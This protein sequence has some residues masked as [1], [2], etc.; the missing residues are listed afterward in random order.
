MGLNE[1]YLIVFD[2]DGTL[3]TSDKTISKKTKDKLIELKEKGN[4]ISLAS[5]RPPRTILPYYDEL[6]LDG[7]FVSY[8][9]ACLYDPKE[10]RPIRSIRLKKEDVLNFISQFDEGEILEM[11][12]ESQD[13]VYYTD[14]DSGFG[15]M[16]D[17]KAM[18]CKEGR[19]EDI[20][21]DDC[22]AFTFLVRDEEIRQKALS[23]DTKVSLRFWFDTR[24]VG[25]LSVPDI[26][27]AYGVKEL[28]QYHGIDREHTICF[29]DA[30]NDVEML[31]QAGISFAMKNSAPELKKIAKYV[32]T[33]D[34][35]HDGIYV[36][37]LKLFD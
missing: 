25:E 4:I 12:A 24:L 1:R 13:S 23:I 35:D 7:L 8:N 18:K 3:L 15:R 9:G 6:E 31:S 37:L 26:N 21:D 5:G 10:N 29:G 16:F 2:L 17:N 22:Y 34:N 14:M 36:E 32:T 19:F 20:L 27:K 28:Q 11:F 30:S 33:E